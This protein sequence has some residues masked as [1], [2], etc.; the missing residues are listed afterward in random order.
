MTSMK[1]LPSSGRVTVFR[2]QSALRGCPT[3]VSAGPRLGT[4]VTG[5]FLPLV[6]GAL[7]T[8]PAAVRAQL[9][10][11]TNNSTLTITRGCPES[12]VTVFSDC[13]TTVYHLPGTSGWG[14]TFAYRPT[15]PWNPQVPTSDPSF[16]VGM[17]RFGFTITGGTN[18]VVVIEATTDLADP[19]W[20]P[21]ATNVLTDGSAYFS[22]S[23]W[24]D[25]PARFY[26]LRSP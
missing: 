23:R 19:S 1:T 25:D 7:L 21:V 15:A 9:E 14:A 12:L 3:R 2:R 6:L 10:Y 4:A 16:G 26:R 17:N 8:L 11:E 24:T 20:L 5:W 22:D 13:P 18:L